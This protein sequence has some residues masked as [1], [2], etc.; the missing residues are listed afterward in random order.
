[1][2]NSSQ[3]KTFKR[4]LYALLSS[5]GWWLGVAVSV[6]LAVIAADLIEDKA[7]AEADY[8][9][10]NAQ[11]AI[12]A[13]VQSYIDVLRGVN[14]LFYTNDQVTRAQFRTYVS[15]L[16][17]ERSFPGIR[18][19]NFARHIGADERKSFEAAVRADTSV[20]PGGYPAFSITPPGEREEYHVLTY[21][22]PVDSH[23]MSFGLD[24]ASNQRVAKS[25]A[26]SRDSGQLTSSGRLIQIVGPEQHVGMSMRMPLYRPGMPLRTVEERRAAYYGSV[27]AGFDINKLLEGAVAAET[28]NNMRFKIY[29]AG[30]SEAP[31]LSGAPDPNRLLF[32]SG[33]PAGGFDADA[34]VFS[35]KVTMAVG[36]RIW[37]LEFSADKSAIVQHLD[38]YLPWL[39]L[40]I[41]LLGSVLLY[42]IYY[43]L[44]LAR[45]HAAD[46]ARE[47][48]RDL[49]A[50]EASLAEAQH[51]AHLGNWVLDP[52]SGKMSWSAEMHRIFG[53]DHFNEPRFEDFLRRVHE[54][55]REH[56]RTCIEQAMHDSEEWEG[57]HRITQRS[58]AVRWVH[59]V[60]RP[61]SQ[62]DQ[63][64]RGIIMDIT[65]RKRTV[66]ALQRSQELLRDLTAHQDRIKE[67]E[68]KRIAREIHDELGQTLLA[69][70]ID[71][72]MLDAR[73]G[74]SHPLLNRKVRGALQHID[75]TVRTVRT[76]INNLRPAVLD[77]G[78]TAAIEWQINEF[79]RRSGIACELNLDADE[80]VVDDETATALFRVLQE[81][82]TNIIRHAKADRVSISLH[83][84]DGRLKME[85]QDNGIGLRPDY[86]LHDNAFGLVGV[87]ERI[88]ALNGEFR[89]D[90]TPGQGT[91]LIF[92]IPLETGDILEQ[93]RVG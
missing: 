9:I 22:E 79:R 89:I 73:T 69:L 1:M 87:E 52:S 82:L 48:T 29:D 74:D 86:R 54:E 14:A 28:L 92:I 64:V 17:L 33:P 38:A 25:L 45:Q 21:L 16:N 46:L 76:I 36:P 77:L 61:G 80:L 44:S 43:S 84:E 18:S 11:L 63:R 62:D 72:A 32:D 42:A 31:R 2:G 88:L 93:R 23:R 49:R 6:S 53:L 35:R 39:A 71:V 70:R 37:E 51:M 10:T 3:M 90:S 20:Q 26:E 58:G 13:R 83:Q 65:E 85:V 55:D 30:P 7:E 12:K 75:A 56:L 68:R 40:V 81:S 4:F 19:L 91:T 50:S 67:E 78:L 47:M 59:T 57:E 27:G 24:I 66:E 5:P 34:E 15:K 8:K 60:A 41:G